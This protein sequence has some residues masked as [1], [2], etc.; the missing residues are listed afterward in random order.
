LKA[1]DITQAKAVLTALANI[2]GAGPYKAEAQSLVAQLEVDELGQPIAFQLPEEAL[3]KSVQLRLA[4][5]EKLGK[6][7]APVIQAGGS[8]G[9]SALNRLSLAA[10]Q[11]ASELDVLVLPSDWP[12]ERKK[13][14][15]SGFPAVVKPLK[16]QALAQW[17]TA[18][19]R[20]QKDGIFSSATPEINDR[21]VQ[22][23]VAG[24]ERAQGIRARWRLAGVSPDGGEVG[25][26]QS[27]AQVRQKLSASPRNAGLWVDYGNLLWGEG[28][29]SLARLAYDR[30][31]ALNSN[32]ASALS[33]RAVF[34][35]HSTS[36]S[37]EDPIVALKAAEYLKRAISVEDFHLPS[38]MNL[39]LL[40]NYYRLFGLAKPFW[41]QVSVKATSADAWDGLAITLQG[42]GKRAEAQAAFQK[43]DTA[44]GVTGRFARRYHQALA[45]GSCVDRKSD[46]EAL[47]EV[48]A[49]GFEKQAIERLAQECL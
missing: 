24:V 36:Q 19:E 48:P 7:L 39:A 15:R 11:A 27:L 32:S 23:Q 34:E 45:V 10:W 20:A 28:R 16:T 26:S 2:K 8:A 44:G 42:L 17:K 47:K 46:I 49:Q 1:R 35:L 9:L 5:L 30:A 3:K 21:L 12:E 38:R 31:L 41:D 4:Y 37:T 25:N 29:L 22:A 33:N 43:A 6:I 18:W 14:L 13:A 40:Y